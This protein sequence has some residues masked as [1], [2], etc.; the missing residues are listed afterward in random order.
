MVITDIESADKALA[1][2]AE[3]ERE[4]SLI[5]IT[6]DEEVDAAKKRGA[7]LA[8]PHLERRKE[9]GTALSVFAA[10]RRSELFGKAKSLQ[11]LHGVFGFRLS[12][13][14]ATLKGWNWKKVLSAV[15][16]MGT[17]LE[18][19]AIFGGCVRTKPELDKEAVRKLSEADMARIGCKIQEEDEFF[20]ETKKENVAEKAA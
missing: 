17:S 12:R 5:E 10:S 18:D 19:L 9:L 3:I 11:R 15:Q 8:K 2:L 7:E 14:L 4:L 16:G 13:K 20:I 1:E 6:V